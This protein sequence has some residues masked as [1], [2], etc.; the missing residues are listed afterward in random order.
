MTLPRELPAGQHVEID[1][2]A[3]FSGTLHPA[4]GEIEAGE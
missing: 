1:L 2:H 4:P 3:I